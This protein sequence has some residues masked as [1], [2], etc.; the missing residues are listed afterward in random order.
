MTHSEE[1]DAPLP[2]RPGRSLIP[3]PGRSGPLARIIL[4]LT[5]V[6][7]VVGLSVRPN[8]AG[9]PD[10]D[11]ASLVGDSYDGYD[12]KSAEQLRGDQCVAVDALR[13]GGPN[14]FALAQGAVGLPPDQMHQKLNRDIYNTKDPLHQAY[15]ADDDFSFQWQKK[16]QDR[17][18]AFGD[19][20]RG[21]DM[22]PGEP[23]EATG[24]YDQIGLLPWIYQSYNRTEDLFG[25]FYETSPTADD[26][27]KAAAVAIGDQLY[28]TGGTPEEQQAW[29]LWK[30]NSGKIEPN[31]LF[32]PRVFADDARIFLSSG[33]FPH[34]A[35]APDTPEFRVAVED[36]KTRFASCA[37]HDPIDPN[38]VL[39]KEVA[40]AATEWQQEIAS[41][42]TQRQ[43]ILAASATA[44]KALQDG[45]FA[46]GKL[47]GQSWI[48]DYSTGWLDYYSEGGLGWIRDGELEI[49]VPGAAGKCLDVQGSG[50][51]NG[52]PVQLN[53]CNGS[54]AQR[55]ELYYESGYQLRNIN[56]HKCL[57]MP[58]GATADGTKIQIQDCDGSKARQ[59]KFDVR[60]AGPLVNAATSKCVHLP[61]F[62]NSKDAVLSTCNSSSAQKF[63]IVAKTH[64]G[65]APA[66]ADV[67]KAK[68]NITNA[69]AE[70]KKQLAAI[71]AQLST[72][73]KVVTASDSALQAAYGIADANGAPRG[74]GLLV[75][76]QKDQVTKGAAAALTAMV[77]AGETAE[78]ATRASAGDSEAVT[79]RALAQAAQSKAEFRKKAAEAAEWQAKAAADAAKIHRDN[80]KKD[81]ETAEAKLADALKAEGDAKAAA[82][83][84]H[85]KRLAAEAEEKTAKAEKENAAAKQAEA[86]EH[87]RNAETEAGK[88]KDAKDK[89]EAAEK[90][91]ESKRDDAVEAKDHAKAMRDDAWDAKQKADAARAKADAKDAYADSLDSG[92][93]ADAAR[94][95]ANDADKAADDAEAAAGKARSEADAATQAAA[96]AD[97]AATRAEAA[98]KRARS[99]ADAAQAAKLRA[100]AAVKTATS[101][102]A[103]AIKA[104][105]DASAEAKTAVA[106]AD[107]AEQHAKDAKTQAN[108][109]NAE[110]GKALAAAA[111]AAGFAHVTAQAAVDA[112]KAAQQ[113]AAPANDAIQLGSAYVDTDSVA[114]LVVLTGQGSKTIADQQQAVADAHAKNAAAEAQAA[115]N[116]ADQ[117]KGDAKEAYQHAA[118]AAQYAADARGYSKEALGYAADAA[119]AASAAAASLARTVDYDQQ[120]TEDAAAADKAAGN[121]EG[122]AKDARDSADAAELDAE[123]ARSAAAQAEQ[124]AKDA[125][126]AADRADAA[127]TEAEQAAKDADK[128]AKDA[129]D[130]ARQTETKSRNDQIETG[131]GGVDGVFFKTR[132]EPVGDPEILD[133]NNCNVIVHVGD[134]IITANI[135]S[136]TFVEIYLCTAKDI[137]D[138]QSGC[139]AS[140]TLFIHTVELK[141]QTEK[142]TYTITPQEFN[143]AVAK[144]FI[145]ALT[146]DFTGCWDRITGS[147]GTLGNCGWAVFDIASLVFGNVAIKAIK[148]G[149]TALDA[150]LKTGIAIEDAWKALRTAGLTEAAISG[151]VSKLL[152]TKCFPA[153]TKVA[154]ADGPKSIEDI[155]VGDRVWS[156]DPVTGKQSLQPVLHLFQHTVDSLVRIRTADGQ[157]EATDSHRFWVRD[158]GWV[159]AGK[160]RAGDTLEARDGRSEQVLG[161]TVVKGSIGVYNF[162]VARN[163][164]YY[165]YAG[166]TPVLVHNDCIEAILKDLAKDGDRIFLGIAPWVDDLAKSLGGTTFNGDAFATE[167]PEALGMG[168]RPIW[169]VGVERA[170]SNPAVD[171][172]VSLDGVQG[173]ATADEALTKLLQ[174][175]ETITP[176]DWE[177]VR[178]NGY[179]TA[180]EMTQLRKSVRLGDR[181]WSSIKWY[182]TNA[183][184]VVERVFPERFKYAN[185]EP[186]PE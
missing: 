67:D 4:L 177:T 153:G 78:A 90:T 110:A 11:D 105:Q 96:D 111:K 64:T 49:Q 123:A 166:S 124:D 73:Q 21:L 138:V 89:A 130:A 29:A 34:T 79:Q 7:V 161:T 100:D 179:G 66:K 2:S 65:S 50:K 164:T 1:S 26:D 28:T 3:S 32:V 69:Q 114:G 139:P 58:S 103:D 43:Q 148:D 18:Y 157:V 181:S 118:N 63:R 115:K 9:L 68:A 156:Q 109:A 91:A 149:V 160:L 44:T 97:A 136:K 151:I 175:G 15:S 117:A 36:L 104:S 113:V 146:E 62:D 72:A 174:R 142:V 14:L 163:H 159:E 128:Y 6:A 126:A 185:G 143:D 144:G 30:K 134:C 23:E 170:V 81:K 172:S 71:N 137:P 25:P 121:A 40:Q 45:A 127:A 56:A 84:A 169:T 131:A 86:A 41:Q 112:G 94:A 24:I 12:T 39:G 140:D 5:A 106:L 176:G 125:R 173:A 53:T 165:V 150:A 88:A 85:A 182:R 82:A 54:A 101:A 22:Y 17:E 48:A 57:G 129:Q 33:G 35:P 158:R 8:L 133:K 61:T 31:K 154:T 184:G 119:K 183:K 178:R 38:R 70:A 116:L 155:E 42:A 93:D 55:W 77:K 99:D 19:P 152:L 92:D 167:L 20:V 51:A 98:A 108:A 13:K 47:L 147:G 76:L 107:E 180:W 132:A 59:W 186:V 83:D 87:R 102:A 135:T 145:K 168:K 74:R 122:Y 75:G 52:T 80:A 37:W 171:L 10:H 95:A 16:V 60:S 141:P 120:A 162:E 46:L 27:T